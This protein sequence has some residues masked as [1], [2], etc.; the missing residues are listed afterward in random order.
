MIELIRASENP[1]AARSALI[2]Q[3][4]LS[5]I[6]AQAVLDL[7]LQRL[8]GME[9]D[10]IITEHEEIQKRIAELKAILASAQRID[11]IVREE[12]EE[13]KERFGEDRRTE[14]HLRR[15]YPEQRIYVLKP[16]SSHPISKAFSTAQRSPPMPFCRAKVRGS[17]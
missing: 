17:A 15:F 2:E 9:R 16:A 5:E 3:Y 11:A 7:Q 1:A 13:V 4:E 12:L 8:T 10:K 14:I 6:Q